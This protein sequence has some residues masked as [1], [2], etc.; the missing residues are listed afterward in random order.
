MKKSDIGLV[1]L[2]VMGENLVINMEK[3]RLL[4]VRLQPYGTES[5]A[6]YKRQGKG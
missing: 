5:N 3:P 2:A 1:G 6:I 4:R